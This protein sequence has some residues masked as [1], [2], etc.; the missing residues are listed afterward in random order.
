MKKTTKK[1]DGQSVDDLGAKPTGPLRKKVT[2]QQLLKTIRDAT[3][4]DQAL[5]AKKPRS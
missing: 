4:P 3:K 5:V 1:E 2:A